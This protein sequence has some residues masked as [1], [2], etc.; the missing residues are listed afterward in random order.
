M[1]FVNFINFKKLP[2]GSANI[3]ILWGMKISFVTDLVCW[4]L[5]KTSD[6]MVPGSSFWT[7]PVC[8][9]QQ[10]FLSPLRPCPH[11]ICSIF[12]PERDPATRR[13]V[14]LFDTKQYWKRK[15]SELNLRS[16]GTGNVCF[17][18]IWA[19]NIEIKNLKLQTLKI[20]WDLINLCLHSARNLKEHF[21]LSRQKK[22]RWESTFGLA[23]YE[24]Y[25]QK[26]TVKM[27]KTVNIVY[28]YFSKIFDTVSRNI[29]AE[30]LPTLSLGKWTVRSVENWLNS[31][32]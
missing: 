8:I 15:L 31:R 13:N 9:F 14:S 32:P 27:G 30:K 25:L 18:L 23:K 17:W 7:I 6:H 22:G 26:I 12:Q 29:L 3:Y 1:P 4:H 28:L 19:M 5:L 16:A 21:E 11:F 24:N 2:L 10:Q 20:K